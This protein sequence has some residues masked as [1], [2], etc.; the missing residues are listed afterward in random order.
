LEEEKGALRVVF[1]V[2]SFW[3]ESGKTGFIDNALSN[4]SNILPSLTVVVLDVT[5]GYEGYTDYHAPY[6]LNIVGS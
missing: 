1:L 2:Q 3:Y 4:L 5:G 6:P